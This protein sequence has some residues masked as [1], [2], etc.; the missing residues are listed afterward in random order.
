[1]A[2]VFRFDAATHTYHDAHG[3][4]PHITNLLTLAGWV[5]DTWFT[6]EARDRGTAVHQLAA[7]YDLGALTDE[8]VV[9]YDGDFKAY[10][11]GHAMCA[12]V[13]R[14]AWL[15]IEVGFLCSR[16]RF[17][18]TPDRGGVIRKAKAVLEIKSGAPERSHQIQTA[19]QAVLLA[20][21]FK[22]PPRAI[23]RYCEYLDERG[24]YKVDQHIDRRDFVEADRILRRFC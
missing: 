5:D 17:A 7:Q 19:L 6:A 22:L 3:E 24:R 14:P 8:D 12:R 4:V 13:L 1:M 23:Q 16:P 15:H 21:E 20:D 10:L 11:L 9:N 18:G 2:R